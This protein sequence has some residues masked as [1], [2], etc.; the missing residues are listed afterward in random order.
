MGRL[1]RDKIEWENFVTQ[2]SA[3]IEEYEIIDLKYLG[4]PCEWERIL[5]NIKIN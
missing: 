2:L 3:L 1:S 4:F 5:R